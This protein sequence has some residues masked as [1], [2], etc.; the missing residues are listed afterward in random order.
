MEDA[1]GDLQYVAT[2]LEGTGNCDPDYTD[3]VFVL[4][5]SADRAQ[6]A[7]DGLP[8]SAARFWI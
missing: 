7:L 6:Q 2:E 5:Q 3:D 4:F 1:S 8:I